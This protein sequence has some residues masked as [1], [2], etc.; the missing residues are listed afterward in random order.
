MKSSIN[1]ALQSSIGNGNTM[2]E[3][4]R[5]ITV[6]PYNRIA[7]TAGGYSSWRRAAN[8]AL[9]VVLVCPVLRVLRLHIT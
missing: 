6:N 5:F 9:C 3:K 1:N 2:S 7:E 8:C 4:V